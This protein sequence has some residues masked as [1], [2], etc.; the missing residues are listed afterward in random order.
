M[1][2]LCRLSNHPGLDGTLSIFFENPESRKICDQNKKKSPIL[3]YVLRF[4]N[5]LL[6]CSS[7]AIRVC[8][9]ESDIQNRTKFKI[10][11]STCTPRPLK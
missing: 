8:L 1:V 2:C 4:S 7:E 6:R 5:E 10:D 3:T 9:I 11:S